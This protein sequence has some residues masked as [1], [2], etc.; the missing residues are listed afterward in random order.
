[1]VSEVPT[2]EVVTISNHSKEPVLAATV[3]AVTA[4]LQRPDG[5]SDH[6]QGK[7]DPAL[8]GVIAPGSAWR[9]SIALVS[10]ESGRPLRPAT[11]EKWYVSITFRL[12]DSD[13]R[14]WERIENGPPRRI[15][16]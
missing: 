15:L 9:T 3:I 7:A 10:N 14:W 16:T 6:Y 13:G 12:L 11:D 8:N 5:T 2:P 1:M 4:Q